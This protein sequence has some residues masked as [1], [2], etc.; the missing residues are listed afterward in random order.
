[1]KKNFICIIT[2][3]ALS[4]FVSAGVIREEKKVSK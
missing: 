4:N 2:L 1:M 3:I